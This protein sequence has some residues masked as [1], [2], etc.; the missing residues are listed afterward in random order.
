MFQV[1]QFRWWGR[2]WIL[3]RFLFG[4]IFWRIARV[5]VFLLWSLHLWAGK[6]PVDGGIFLFVGCRFVDVE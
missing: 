4:L 2:R 6:V 3:L 1:L 5:E